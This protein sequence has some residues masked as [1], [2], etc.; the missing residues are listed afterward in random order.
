MIEHREPVQIH[1]IPEIMPQIDEILFQ[2]GLFKHT[3]LSGGYI[4]F[5]D[6]AP[7]QIGSLRVQWSVSPTGP[8]TLC[9]QQRGN[10]FQSH[11]FLHTENGLRSKLLSQKI[12]DSKC[13][14][15]CHSLMIG[16]DDLN[17]E[18]ES[19]MRGHY[20]KELYFAE[21][22]D[23]LKRDRSRWNVFFFLGLTVGFSA[24]SHGIKSHLGNNRIYISVMDGIFTAAVWMFLLMAI[25]KYTIDPSKIKTN[26]IVIVVAALA[27]AIEQTL[28]YTVFA[29]SLQE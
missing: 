2:S 12:N 17:L 8:L 29:E 24:I 20:P 22:V 25:V 6:Q 21:N 23:D 15:C 27:L 1:S 28:I 11:N 3:K 14:S 7:D 13:P 10:S 5:Y 18:F 19:L 9:S 16:A 4:Y 26:L